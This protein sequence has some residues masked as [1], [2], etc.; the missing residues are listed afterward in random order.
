MSAD[1]VVCWILAWP[2]VAAFYLAYSVVEQIIQKRR[3]SPRITE[4]APRTSEPSTV[5]PPQKSDMP[6]AVRGYDTPE[7]FWR[8]ALIHI[9]HL[10]SE[11]AKHITSSVSCVLIRQ[12]RI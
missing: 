11:V 7:L 2:A 8:D 3:A 6:P 4:L 1:A 12:V 5:E 9:R 10:E